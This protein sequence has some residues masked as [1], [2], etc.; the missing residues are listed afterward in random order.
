M[1]SVGGNTQALPGTERSS[2]GAFLRSGLGERKAV[3]PVSFSAFLFL[4]E[5]WSFLNR[6]DTQHKQ[7][8]G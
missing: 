6:Q 5:L 3:R 4:S 2:Q 7:C 1:R 8:G